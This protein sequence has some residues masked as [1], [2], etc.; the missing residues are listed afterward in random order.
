MI[1]ASLTHYRITAKL[2]GGR[3][4]FDRD[5]GSAAYNTQMD[6]KT[7]TKGVKKG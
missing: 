3:I 1:A 5:P 7:N 6:T 4:V 2:G